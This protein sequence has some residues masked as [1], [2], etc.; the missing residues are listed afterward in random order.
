M[1]ST[2]LVRVLRESFEVRSAVNGRE[3]LQ[4]IQDR[5]PDLLISDIMMPEM[6]GFG[7]LRELRGQEVTSDLPIIFL[8]ARAGDEATVE[9]LESG[10]DDYLVKPFSSKE[11]RARVRTQLSMLELRSD[12]LGERKALVVRDEF[13]SIASHELN[14]PLTALKIQ[15]QSLNRLLDRGDLGAISPDRIKKTIG[16]F[17]QQVDNISRLVD[18]LLDVSRISKGRLQLIR[19]ETDL[20]EEVRKTLGLYSEQISSAKCPVTLDLEE[21][22]RGD[23]DPSRVAQIVANL[24]VNAVKYASGKLIRIRVFAKDGIANLTVEDRGPVISIDSLSKIF[25]RFERVGASPNLGGLGLGPYISQQIAASHGGEIQVESTLGLG[26]RFSVLLPLV[27][28][29]S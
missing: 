20:A 8:S 24:I 5:R 9:G 23:W 13:I 1:R 26:T 19:Q 16:L 22:V 3:A 6:N 28:R 4:L 12:L 11:W 17:E 15:L 10:A 29:E 27:R 18:D 25:N 2:Y 21:G 14:T 7:L